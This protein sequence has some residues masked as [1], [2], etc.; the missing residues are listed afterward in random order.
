MEKYVC[1]VCGYIHQGELKNDI[2]C[3]ICKVG[4]DKF[5]LL[6]SNNT[7]KDFIV[8]DKVK[9]NELVTS[10]YLKLKE[11]TL[12][13]HKAGEFISVMP[14]DKGEN[15]KEVRQYTLSMKPGEDFY[16]IS[17][18]KEEMG[19]VSSYL[20]NNVE[21]SDI[22]KATDSLGEFT[23]SDSKRPLVLLSGGIGVTPMM[24]MLYEA[25]ESGR[26]I[27]FIQAVLNSSAHT[28]KDELEKIVDENSQVKKAIFY[29]TP[30][31][32]DKLNKNYDFEGFVSDRWIKDNVPQ[33]GKFYLCG[34]VGF[35][36]HIYNTLK[37]IGINEKEI[38]Y[39]MFGAY[40]DLAE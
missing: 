27:L 11:G 5:E 35:M 8:V 30:L 40:Q 19:I 38:N 16:R 13:K 17:V 20:H 28:F 23:L 7:F 1:T 6:E 25:L 15:S 21:V 9:E 18:K 22:I 34:P 32:E 26:D 3:P 2:I 4:F 31:E 33:N 24:S 36:K 29:Q 10:F 14:I 12:K 39:E 37:S